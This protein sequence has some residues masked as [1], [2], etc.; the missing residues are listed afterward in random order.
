IK[1]IHS[2]I[3]IAFS[4]NIYQAAGHL[5]IFQMSGASSDVVASAFL[6]RCHV[7]ARCQVT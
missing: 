2:Y 7:L 6:T 3:L 5:E 4:L 1:P